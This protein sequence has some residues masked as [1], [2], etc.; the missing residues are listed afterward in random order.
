MSI[1]ALAFSMGVIAGKATGGRDF[2][3][4]LLEDVIA[5]GGAIL[6]VSRFS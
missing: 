6:I 3:I 4:A 1:F 5:V 2:T